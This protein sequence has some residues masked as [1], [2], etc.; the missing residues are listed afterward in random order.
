MKAPSW[1]MAAA[2][3]AVSV[4]A[5]LIMQSLDF[6]GDFRLLIAMAL[7]AGASGLVPKLGA[8]RKENV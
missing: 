2:F 8:R 4:P 6:G 1:M 3:V 5:V 7:G